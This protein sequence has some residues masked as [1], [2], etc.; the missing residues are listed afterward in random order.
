[1][2][3]ARPPSRRPD[4]TLRFGIGLRAEH[5]GDLVA[6]ADPGARGLDFLEVVSE[7][8]FHL[9]G[10]GRRVLTLL[11]ERLPILPHGVGLSLGGPDPLDESYL[12]KLHELVRFLDPP[13]VSDHLCTSSAHGVQYH[14]LLPVPLTDATLKR[15]ASRI[16]RLQ[17]RFGRSFVIENPTQYLT[18]PGAEMSEAQL[19]AELVR[20][21][22]CGILL[23]VNNLHVNFLNLGIDP[24][25]FLDILPAGSVLQYHLAGH[26]AGEDV[27]IDSHGAPVDPAVLA[28]Y[29]SALEKV[30][31][32]WTLL[33]RDQDLPGLEV[34]LDELASVREAA[35]TCDVREVTSRTATPRPRRR[36]NRVTQD[37]PRRHLMGDPD[38]SS[39]DE[40]HAVLTGT[41]D[42]GEVAA[43]WQVP[44]ASL[45][46]YR[47]FVRRHTR[48]VI[49]ELFPVFFA[50]LEGAA[51][52]A[53]VDHC[54]RE[55]PLRE[56]VLR[57]NGARILE[58][59]T[60]VQ[61]HFG[62]AS[63]QL[64]VAEVEWALAEALVAPDVTDVTSRSPRLEPTLETFQVDHAVEDLVRAGPA[65]AGVA[66]GD[67]PPARPGIVL[68]WRHASTLAAHVVRADEGLLLAL[69][70]VIEDHDLATAARES[71]CDLAHIQ[72]QLDRAAAMGILRT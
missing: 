61:A 29:R 72:R 27:V 51:R 26:T 48:E 7:N 40:L 11:R 55:A 17:D 64:E 22:G 38:C 30:G 35:G 56:P 32:A 12:E 58:E 9:S 14:D 67:A 69:K 71:G 3:S 49:E 39:H 13:W 63:W 21:T 41:A 52:E 37:S 15:V 4:P 8:F 2:A 42:P 50:S 60:S 16:D 43:R 53:L 62:L 45:R 31:P 6:L 66:P 57:D 23:D 70:I 68:V 54:W 34:L 5:W 36:R 10:E 46:L 47:N 24:H 1:M 25:Q 65:T 44:P 59:L 20:R 19:L 18:L 33:E 28:L